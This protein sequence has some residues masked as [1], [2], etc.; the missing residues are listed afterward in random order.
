[1]RHE[2]F[3]AF[4]EALNN[5]IRH[6]DA[7]EVQIAMNVVDRRLIITVGDNGRGFDMTAGL[8]GSDGLVN[9]RE[10]LVKLGG[11]CDIHS[12]PGE[13]TTVQFLLPLGE[14]GS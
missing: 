1:M 6:S 7:S 14:E 4:K 9:M 2:V 12:K 13:G 5:A 10:R 8:P 11:R 3:L